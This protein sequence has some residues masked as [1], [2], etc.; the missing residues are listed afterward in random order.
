MRINSFNSG[1]TC[2]TL[3]EI[4]ITDKTPESRS[5]THA[6]T[7]AHTYTCMR[8]TTSAPC[9]AKTFPHFESPIPPKKAHLPPPSPRAAR[10]KSREARARQ[11]L[12]AGKKGRGDVA[13]VKW[14]ETNCAPPI[15]LPAG[16]L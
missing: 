11:R 16:M 12:C 13:R 10:I 9:S 2:S 7:R 4:D 3:A 15:S 1:L 6:H 8:P 14:G 5:R